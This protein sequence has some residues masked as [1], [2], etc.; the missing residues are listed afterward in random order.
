MTGFEH[1]KGRG[2]TAGRE[3]WTP[4]SPSSLWP[5]EQRLSNQREGRALTL[6]TAPVPVKPEQ[7]LFLQGEAL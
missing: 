6:A 7:E 5:E 2:L 1:V 3:G 4:L